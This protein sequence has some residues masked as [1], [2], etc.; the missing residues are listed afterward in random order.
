M[1]TKLITSF[2]F[3]SC[4]SFAQNV[5][6]NVAGLWS[7]TGISGTA[8]T[9]GSGGAYGSVG[10]D[11]GCIGI[12]PAGLGLYRSTDFSVTPLLQFGN[13]QSLY[14]GNNTFDHKTSFALAQGGFV[15]TK[16][17]KKPA[18]N[19]GMGFSGNPNVLRSFSFA[20][21]FQQQN[22]F[23]RSQQYGATNNT[24]SMIDGYASQ[25]NGGGPSMAYYVPLEV[26]LAQ[27]ANLLGQKSNGSS[28]SNLK[29]PVT[30]SG[31]VE[32]RGSINRIDAAFGFNFLDKLYFGFDLAVPILGYTLN[33]SFSEASIANSTNA[34]NINAITAETGFG[35][36]GIVGLIYRPVPWMRVGAAYHLP[37]WYVIHENYSI[38]LANDTASFA[39]N[40]DGSIPA[41]Q[42]G[43]RT[44]MKGDFGAS[45]YYKDHGFISVDYE[46]QNLGASRI[47]VPNDSIQIEPYYNQVITGTYKYTHTIH[48]GLEAAIKVIRIRAGYAFSTSPYK[49]GQQFVAMPAG[50]NDVQNAFSLGFGL[51]LTHFYADLAYV[52][53]WSK[54]AAYQLTN[55]L[56]INSTNTASTLVLTLGW[57]FDAGG[58]NNNN[59]QK[60]QQRKY[61]PPPPVDDQRY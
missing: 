61:T 24:A 34:Y 37:S 23:D 25:L 35:F 7:Q 38:V 19:N 39:P 30:Q 4:F 17:F 27:Y 26:Q 11:M 56:P 55:T 59:Q 45:F 28:F 12:N 32:T 33:N 47:H 48:A 43:L 36:N 50:Y 5:P 10:A 44:P 51:R 41:F 58:K 8:R 22:I 1:R 3:L 31:D 54:D 20:L 18:E 21:N 2:L 49:N 9:M 53:N 60:T 13:S 57:K 15:F 14:D 6:P 40:S 16:L 52:Y 42:Y 29:A 46:V